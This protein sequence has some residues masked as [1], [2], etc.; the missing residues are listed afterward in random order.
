MPRLS[1]ELLLS[2]RAIALLTALFLALQVSAAGPFFR[3]VENRWT[4]DENLKDGKRPAHPR[5]AAAAAGLSAEGT[6]I[7]AGGPGWGRWDFSAP[8]PLPT[9]VVPFFLPP[10]GSRSGIY[11]LTADGGRFPLIE[12]TPLRD[13]ALNFRDKVKGLDSYSVRFEGTG[14]LLSGVKFIQPPESGGRNKGLYLAL[15]CLALVFARGLALREKRT[16]ALAL[17]TAAGLLLRWSAF[18][19]YWDVPLAGDAVGYWN[20]GRALKLSALFANGTREPVFIWLLSLFK[21]LFGDSQRTSRFMTLVF[22]CSVIPMT[23]LLA[24]RLELGAFACLL[25]AGLAAFNPFAVFMSVQ[26]YQLEFFTFLILVFSVLWLR[27]SLGAA[28]SAGAALILTRLQS[29]GAVFPLAALAAWR[30]RGKP[31]KLGPYL[32]PPLIALAVLLASAK[33]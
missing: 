14:A 16:A 32:L 26:G 15:F 33:A 31:G 5:V 27:G 6:V 24:K 9:T 8:G 30:L 29:A 25:A 3:P 23:W 13:R 22:S 1:A 20:Y 7:G 4:L 28:G 2:W 10:D 17:I 18:S 11:L 12:N 19:D 21:A